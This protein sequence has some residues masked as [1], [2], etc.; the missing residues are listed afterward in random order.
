MLKDDCTHRVVS[1]VI[2]VCRGSSIAA[3]TQ[4]LDAWSL[5][6][7]LPRTVEEGTLG[8]WEPWVQI[9]PLGV[10]EAPD[11]LPC[12][13]PSLPRTAVLKLAALT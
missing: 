10:L 6:G 4:S 5:R 13:S 9:L 3:E 1:A 2:V 7:M 12:G 11:A 8:A